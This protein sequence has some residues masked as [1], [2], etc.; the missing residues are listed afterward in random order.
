MGPRAA[1]VL[2][3]GEAEA[4]V[5][6][7]KAVAALSAKLGGEEPPSLV[8]WF[9]KGYGARAEPL[10]P[11]L[12]RLA[13]GGVVLGSSAE[14]GLLGDGEEVQEETFALSVLAVRAG[15]TQLFPFHSSGLGQLPALGRGGSWE[16]LRASAASPCLLAFCSLPLARGA[17]PQGWCTLLDQALSQD[18]LTGGAQDTTARARARAPTVIGGLTVGK[19]LFVDGEHHSGG[20]FGVAMLPEAGRA[21]ASFEAVVCQGAVP[22]GPW[23]RI[24]RVANDHVITE[25]DGKNPKRVLEPLLHGPRVP[26]SG[27]TMA[28]ILVDAGGGDSPGASL[29]GG[30]YGAAA[31]LSGRPS[32]VVRP[33]HAWTPEG[34]L[35][36]SPVTDDT[37]YAPGMQIQ[38]HCMNKELALEDLRMRAGY[39]VMAHSGEAPDAAVIIS[40]GARGAQLYEEE[41]VESR[42]LRQAWGQDVPTAGFFAGGEFG[43]VGRRTYV[44]GFTTSCLL[45]RIPPPS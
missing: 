19:H 18:E 44:H 13:G 28:G 41:G 17:N 25:L 24:T 34:H 2:I 42:V 9:A 6:A 8:L 31:P 33:L 10:G 35:V 5:A 11:L 40:C 37:P 26:G 43:P 15:K 21:G 4:S 38:L 39:D 3:R 20:A 27:Q 16:A 12:Q 23:L 29:A 14:A 36:L 45:M 32:C 30:A 1:S 7:E 22:F